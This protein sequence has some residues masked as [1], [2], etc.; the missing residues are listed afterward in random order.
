MQWLQDPNQ[1]NVYKPNNVRCEANRH[2]R[3]KK[4]EYLKAKMEELATNG[5]IKNISDLYR[6]VHY[7]KKGYQPGTNTV[8]KEKGDLVRD[9]HKI[10]ARWRKHLSQLLNVHG[11]SDVKQTEIHKAEPLVHELSAFEIEMSTEKLKRHKSPRIEQT[12][13]ELIKAEG[14]KIWD[15]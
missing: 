1:S 3:N 6:G 14:R 11:S 2:L 4:K 12:P 7:L 13:A 8:Q 9:S 15:P 10:V 5:K